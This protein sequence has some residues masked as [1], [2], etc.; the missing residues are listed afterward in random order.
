M[1]RRQNSPS[2]GDNSAPEHPLIAPL[3]RISDELKLLRTVLDEIRTDL[4]WAVQNDRSASEA[5]M[6]VRRSAGEFISL[7]DEGDAVEVNDGIHVSFGEVESIDD[8]TNEATVILIPSNQ[9]IT[10]SQDSI[11]RVVPDQLRRAFE[12]EVNEAS[13][14]PAVSESQSSRPPAGSRTDR[15]F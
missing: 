9:V 1:S 10:V 3:E 12:S 8:A 11:S 4:Q 2:V 15:L 7:F 14:D 6:P 5:S 13:T